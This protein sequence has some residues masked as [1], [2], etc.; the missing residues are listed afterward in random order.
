MKS[1]RK[2]AV[3]V[4]ILVWVLTLGGAL[5]V[6]VKARGKDTIEF[7]IRNLEQERRD[8]EIRWYSQA[9]APSKLTANGELFNDKANTFASRTIP[10][11]TRI[12]IEYNGKRSIYRCNDRSP[13]YIELTLGGFTKLE[14]PSV[15]VLHN[16]K[17]TILNNI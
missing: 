2:L 16:A 13:D 5:F 4:T 15:G 10:F 1:L 9:E 17:I 12:L 14:N 3:A 7:R 11:G 8:S 6:A